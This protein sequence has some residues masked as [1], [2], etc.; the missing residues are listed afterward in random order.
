MTLTQTKLGMTLK[1]IEKKDTAT[2]LGL[3]KSIVSKETFYHV[4]T[5]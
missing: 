1:S 4:I 5:K 2:E 3:S